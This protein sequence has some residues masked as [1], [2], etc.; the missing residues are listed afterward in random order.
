MENELSAMKNL[1]TRFVFHSI[2]RVRCGLAP[3][4]VE[5]F[6]FGFQLKPFDAIY[7]R[8]KFTREHSSSA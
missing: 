6:L 1:F 7:G 3:A 2:R 5:L 8:E 4:V